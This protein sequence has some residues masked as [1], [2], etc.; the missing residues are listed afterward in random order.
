MK[1]SIV[2]LWKKIDAWL[3]KVEHKMEVI[4]EKLF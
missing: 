4:A 2:N 3:S 1:T